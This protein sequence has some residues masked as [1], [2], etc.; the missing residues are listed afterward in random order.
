MKPQLGNGDDGRDDVRLATAASRND[1]RNDLTPGSL[2][3]PTK[4]G[5]GR[6][7]GTHQNRVNS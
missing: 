2:T 1:L 7:T 4:K 6:D 5:L 3:W